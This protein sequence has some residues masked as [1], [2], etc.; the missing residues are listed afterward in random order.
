MVPDVLDRVRVHPR[1]LVIGDRPFKVDLEGPSD[2]EP[3][4]EV[5]RGRSSQGPF[6]FEAGPISLRGRFADL[7][8]RGEKLTGEG[9]SDR[10]VHEQHAAVTGLEESDGERCRST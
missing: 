3:P 7:N 4:V 10:A 2:R 5:Y 9:R 8:C 6:Y 1:Q